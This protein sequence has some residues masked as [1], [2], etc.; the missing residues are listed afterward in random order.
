[1]SKIIIEGGRRLVGRI[2]VSG[3]KNAALPIMAAALLTADECVF[4]NIPNIE[5]TRTMAELLSRLGAAVTYDAPGHRIVIQAK[6]LARFTAPAELV[7]RMRASFLV[8]GPLL[9]RF[10]LAGAPHPG[11]CAIGTRPVNVDIKGLAAMGASVDIHDRT[12]ILRADGLRGASIY[13]DY[14]SHT[15]T[16]NLLLAATLAKGTTIIK[17]ASAEPEVVCLANCLRAMGARI[18]GD[19]TSVI[20]VEGVEELHGVRFTVCPD[21][22]E[23]GTYAIA[24]AITGGEL[25]LEDVIL[26]HMEPLTH[27]LLEVGV[28]VA[29]ADNRYTVRANGRLT[30]SEVQTLP[31]PGFPTDLQSCFSTLLT[32]AHG[33]SMVHERVYDNRLLYVDELK[34][35]G[36]RI[37][38]HGQ[39]AIIEGPTPLHGAPVR[40]LDIRSGAA[41]V[42]A[43]LVADGVTEI[44]DVHHVER[45]YDSLVPKLRSLGARIERV[46]TPAGAVAVG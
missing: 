27:K 18:E 20:R 40:A 14:P 31:Y 4:E 12:Y 42:L 2:R 23:A 24:A 30:A 41:L 17:H 15:G 13:L 39:T 46:S 25:E 3:A 7:Q 37:R 44:S 8:T 22:I 28:H 5:D 21:R 26:A 32:Q 34:K 33:T 43:G 36:A 11:G 9:S 35:M 16:E 38:V 29:A 10:G 19:G 1:M 6:H 45:G